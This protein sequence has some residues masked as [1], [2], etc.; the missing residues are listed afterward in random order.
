MKLS[1]RWLNELVHIADI[2][3]REIALRLTMATAEIE[4]VEAVEGIP[5]GVVVGR[6]RKVEPHPESAHLYVARIDVGS[7]VLQVVSG[8]PNTR[9]GTHV[10][11]ALE[12]TVL[13]GGTVG[14]TRIR[15]VES[16]GMACS[17]MEL[18]M[19]EDHSGL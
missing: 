19:S 2:D 14:R 6:I 12:G 4:G 17:E 1:C 13:G 9:E 5:D 16:R 18:R 7:G 15:G 3:P 10:P 8:A 11:V